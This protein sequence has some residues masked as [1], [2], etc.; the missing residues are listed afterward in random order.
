MAIS[1]TTS[2]CPELGGDSIAKIMIRWWSNEKV[3]EL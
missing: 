3:I 2:R 1:E